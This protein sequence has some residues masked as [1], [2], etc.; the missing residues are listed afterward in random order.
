LSKVI[1]LSS[2][3]R[4]SVTFHTGGKNN[5]SKIAINFYARRCV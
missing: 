2:V 1:D 5:Y 3:V 4:N